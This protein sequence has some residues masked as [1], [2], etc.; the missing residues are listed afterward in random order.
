MKLE[1]ITPILTELARAYPGLQLSCVRGTATDVLNA[2]KAGDVEVAIT[3]SSGIEWERFDYWPLF[4][5]GFA[6]IVPKTHALSKRKKI[7]LADAV[8]EIYVFRPYCENDIPRR[9]A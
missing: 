5:E 6:L 2:L 1:L 3:A 7:K 8:E 4:E 9:R